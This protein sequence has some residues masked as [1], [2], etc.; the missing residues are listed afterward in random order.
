MK[1]RKRVLDAVSR[2]LQ[3]F[4]NFLRMAYTSGAIELFMLGGAARQQF[5][6]PPRRS[7]ARYSVFLS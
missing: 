2:R 1:R 6:Q 5:G 7:V 4:Y 3:A